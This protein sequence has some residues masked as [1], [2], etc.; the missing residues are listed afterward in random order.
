MN[1]GS[2]LFPLIYSTRGLSMLIP[3]ATPSK[4]WFYG[5]SLDWN[6]GSNPV[7]VLDVRLL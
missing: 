3:I 1:S 6:A 4:A 2:K 5:R 7:E